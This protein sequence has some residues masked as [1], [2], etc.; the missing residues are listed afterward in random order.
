MAKLHK[1]SEHRVTKRITHRDN[2]LGEIK[3]NL[4]IC[5]FAGLCY[6]KYDQTNP[7]HSQSCLDLFRRY[8]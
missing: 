5:V 3:S 2:S 6:K 1:T 8:V 4:Q 7:F